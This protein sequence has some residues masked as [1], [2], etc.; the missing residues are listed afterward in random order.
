MHLQQPQPRALVDSAS[1]RWASRVQGIRSI[2]RY[3]P[4]FAIGRYACID[5]RLKDVAN[6][7]V[8]ARMFSECIDSCFAGLANLSIYRQ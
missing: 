5:A 3:N 7:L 2:F 8:P 1:A 6:V 4:C